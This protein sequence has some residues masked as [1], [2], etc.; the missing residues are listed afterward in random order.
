MTL[1]VLHILDAT[2]RGGAEMLTLDVCRNARNAGLDLTFVATGG[3]DLEREFERSGAPYF[4]LQ[5]RLPIDPV[6]VKNLRR[7]IKQTGVQ[8]VHAQQAVEA[9]HLYLATRGTGV[10]CVMSLQ[11]YILD[12]KNRIATKMIV[13]RMDAVCPVSASMQEWY[14]SGEGF[15]ITDKYHVLANGVDAARL[16]PTRKPGTPS[17]RE[18]LGISDD[19]ALLGMVGNFYP[20]ER[21]DQ[22]SICRALTA[23]FAQHPNAHFVFVGAV[24]DGAE[25]YHRRCVEHCRDNGIADRVHFVGKRGDIPD[26]LRELDLFIF[27]TVQEGLPVAAVEALML[28]VP[29]IVSDIPPM[30]EVGGAHVPEGLCVEVFKTGSADD[31]AE[32]V[33]AL[34]SNPDKLKILGEKERV[35]TEQYYGI[36]AHLTTLKAIYEN[37]VTDK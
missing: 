24:H 30:L 7:I 18:E 13:P 21:K 33:I 17:L 16:G 10:K 11:A 5:R 29:M 1:K 4:R 6:L 22:W 35:Q 19:R 28:G 32:K 2:N 12:T 25:D 9:I 15:T 34:L 37:L 3:G 14:R 26:L 20:D 8:I 36:E 31:L 27:S 23:I